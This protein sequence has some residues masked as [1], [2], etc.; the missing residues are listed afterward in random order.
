MSIVWDGMVITTTAISS[1]LSLP[2]KTGDASPI[3]CLCCPMVGSQTERI[4]FVAPH[5]SVSRRYRGVFIVPGLVKPDVSRGYL[6][7]SRLMMVERLTRL[8]ATLTHV[9]RTVARQRY[10]KRT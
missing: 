4:M 1:T 3:D 8:E 6:L 2:E 5:P 9:L 10:G 7:K